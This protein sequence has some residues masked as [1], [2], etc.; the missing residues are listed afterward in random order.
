M[1]RFVMKRFVSQTIFI[2]LLA[3]TIVACQGVNPPTGGN[4]AQVPPTSTPVPTAPSVARPTYLVQ[5]G[6]VSNIFD[7]NGRW[8]PRDQ[9][10]LSFQVAG[11]IRRVLVKRGDTVTQNQLL[12]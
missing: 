9:T 11:S 7:F 12:A 10:I 4:N 8:Q 6:D 3:V 2:G 1:K 5:R